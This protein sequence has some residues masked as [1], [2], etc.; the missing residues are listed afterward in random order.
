MKINHSRSSFTTLLFL[1]CFSL[2]NLHAEPLP[3]KGRLIFE[4]DFNRSLDDGEWTINPKYTKAFSI[5]DGALVGKELPDAGHGST[6]R[7]KINT[8]NFVL[9]FDFTFL[10]GRQFNLVLDD[11]TYKEVHAG[12]IARVVFNK[13][14]ITVQDDKTGTMNLKLRTQRLKDPTWMTKNKALMDSKKSFKSFAFQEGKTYRATI[15]KSGNLLHCKVGDVIVKLRSEG[16]SH[17]KLT[18][19]GPTITGGEISFDNL[20][21]WSIKE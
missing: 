6:T 13:K 16:I 10:G 2:C 18:Q 19:F 21:L 1:A 3:T 11:L 5:R 8:P 4:D 9:E 15:T 14:G 7:K 12:H 20:K 17:P